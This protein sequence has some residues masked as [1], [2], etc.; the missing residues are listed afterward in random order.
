MQ[1]G[2]HGAPVRIETRV[3]K[4]ENNRKPQ[5]GPPDET[6]TMVYWVENGRKIE[7][8]ERVAQL[9][10]AHQAETRPEADAPPL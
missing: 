6:I 4:W 2:L 9:E 5:D 1:D 7:D 10:A 3:A 8:P